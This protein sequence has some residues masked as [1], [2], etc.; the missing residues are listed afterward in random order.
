MKMKTDKY[1][2]LRS[3]IADAWLKD[4]FLGPIYEEQENGDIIFTEKAQDRYIDIVNI[5]EHILE[6]NGITKE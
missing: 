5:V 2:E 4:N 6:D 1:V 3:D